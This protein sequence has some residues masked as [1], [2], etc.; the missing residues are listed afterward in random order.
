MLFFLLFSQH[1]KIAKAKNELFL[2]GA[3]VKAFL[4]RKRKYAAA[5]D[6]LEI[7]AILLA[8]T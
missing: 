8:N 7:V 1:R 3:T 4:N 5:L 6:N 2:T